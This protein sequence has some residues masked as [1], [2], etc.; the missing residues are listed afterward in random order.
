[1]HLAFTESVIELRLKHV[2]STVE[3]KRK[4]RFDPEQFGHLNMLK[5]IRKCHHSAFFLPERTVRRSQDE[6]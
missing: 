2:E 5:T 3:I 4:I 1:M 6:I